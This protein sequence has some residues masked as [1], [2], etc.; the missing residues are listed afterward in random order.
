VNK[1]LYNLTDPNSLTHQIAFV[2]CFL[3]ASIGL[4]GYYQPFMTASGI[5]SAIGGGLIYSLDVNSSSAK[6]LGYQAILGVGLGLGI[7]VPM[8]AMQALSDPADM[9][10]NTAIIL[11]ESIF[12]IQNY[13]VNYTDNTY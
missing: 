11:C 8:I 2:S 1:L 4:V 7:Q 3:G 9:A 13:V 10:P 5:F 6:Y 12:F